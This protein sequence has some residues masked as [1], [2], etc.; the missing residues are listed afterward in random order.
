MTTQR[1]CAWSSCSK[2]FVPLGIGYDRIYCPS[3]A[4]RVDSAYPL[5]RQRCS[6]SNECAN[7]D[8]TA[9]GKCS[10]HEHVFNL[11]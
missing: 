1:H 10:W 11:V 6:W 4:V 7:T 2:L 5:T 3:C 8:I 9:S